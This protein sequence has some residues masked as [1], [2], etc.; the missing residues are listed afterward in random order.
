MTLQLGH[1]SCMQ[2]S[3]SFLEWV[4]KNWPEKNSRLAV[5]GLIFKF[6][7]FKILLNLEHHKKGSSLLNYHLYNEFQFYSRGCCGK[8]LAIM[9]ITES[10]FPIIILNAEHKDKLKLY[11]KVLY[12]HKKFKTRKYWFEKWELIY[13]FSKKSWKTWKLQLLEKERAAIQCCLC[14]SL[15]KGLG[16]LSSH[17]NSAWCYTNMTF[18]GVWALFW[19]WGSVVYLGVFWVFFGNVL[20]GDT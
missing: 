11:F 1:C 8:K 6:L 5:V 9:T 19:V 4:V 20:H 12:Q 16:H 18:W 3:N 13:L 10:Y 15:T 2:M 7:L 17:C 14:L